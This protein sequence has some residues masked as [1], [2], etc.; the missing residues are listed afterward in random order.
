MRPV[1]FIALLR[2]TAPRGGG[3]EGWKGLGIGDRSP[4]FLV[5][6]HI[7]SYV[8]ARDRA[9]DVLAVRHR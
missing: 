7:R 9:V 6:A 1:C 4:S 3:R 5:R 2:S 8:E